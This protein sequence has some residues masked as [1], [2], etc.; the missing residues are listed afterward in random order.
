MDE[1]CT[2]CGKIRRV[3]HFWVLSKDWFVDLRGSDLVETEVSR[4][5]REV[6]TP[7]EIHVWRASRAPRKAG[8]L[9]PQEREL[10]PF[11]EDLAWD[12]VRA[13]LRNPRWDAEDPGWYVGQGW[14]P[15]SLQEAKA[16]WAG[17]AERG[18]A[19]SH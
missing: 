6:G 18:G 16:W 15:S 17:V 4:F 5:I 7:A 13:R 19:F 10:V 8:R 14:P 12:A 11:G 1:V 2:D 3:E 9:L